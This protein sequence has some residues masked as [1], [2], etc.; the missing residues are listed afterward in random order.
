MAFWKNVSIKKETALYD[1]VSHLL[2]L[3]LP[4]R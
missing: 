2:I 4:V 3:R 1:C